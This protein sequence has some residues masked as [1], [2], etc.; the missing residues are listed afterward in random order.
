MRGFDILALAATAY[1]ILG[2]WTWGIGVLIIVW[3]A[4]LAVAL[5][6]TGQRR[7]VRRRCVA[8]GAVL[9]VITLSVL[10]ALTGSAFRYLN[11]TADWLILL[12]AGSGVAV[13]GALLVWPVLRL[14][15]R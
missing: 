6:R 14:V 11:G 1:E 3:L 4:L 10:P 9:G 12:A 2:G 5:R 15:A 13:L 8:L 7:G